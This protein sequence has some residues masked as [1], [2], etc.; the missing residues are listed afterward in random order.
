M[1]AIYTVCTYNHIGRALSLADSVRTHCHGAKFVICLIDTIQADA[2]PAGAEVI[3]A[4]EMSLPFLNEMCSK[5]SLLELNSAL[6]PYFGNY[7]FEKYT[8][9]DHLIFLDSDILLFDD[10]H[11]VYDSLNLNSIVIS[12]HSLSTV[13]GGTDFDDRIFLRSGIYNA[14]FFGLKRDLNSQNFLNWWMLKLRNEGFFDSKRGMFA[15]QLWLNLV[16]LYFEKVHV[17]KHPGCNVA[18]WNL[19]ERILSETGGVFYVNQSFPLIFFHYSG[20]SGSCIEENTV[21]Q[22][23][24]RYTFVNRPDVLPVFKLYT[25]SLRKHGFE[26]YNQVYTFNSTLKTQSKIVK[27]MAELYKKVVKKLLYIK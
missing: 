17:L 24:K 15:E 5:Y 13:P 8:D 23:Q 9:T 10:L 18:Y 20:A 12:P 11:P 6:K 1:N 2:I 19:H 14:G 25:D 16:P 7:I 4:E 26:K 22:H 27:G 21:S 3:M